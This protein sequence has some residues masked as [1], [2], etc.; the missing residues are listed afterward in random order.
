METGCGVAAIVSAII[1]VSPVLTID[2]TSEFSHG[3]LQGEN[4]VM[5]FNGGEFVKNCFYIIIS[6]KS[7]R[8]DYNS[9]Y[10]NNNNKFIFILKFYI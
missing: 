10:F 4:E 7:V 1:I 9:R 5:Y 2:A 3:L 8:F 6:L